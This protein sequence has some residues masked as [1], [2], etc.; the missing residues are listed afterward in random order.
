MVKIPKIKGLYPVDELNLFLV[1]NN[2][3]PST[4]ISLDPIYIDNPRVKNDFKNG[5]DIISGFDDFYLAFDDVQDFRKALVKEGL[6]FNKK[7]DS[8]LSRKNIENYFVKCQLENYFVASNKE[9]LNVLVESFKSGNDY[10]IG[11]ALGYPEEA[12]AHYSNQPK[13]STGSHFF[14]ELT[15]GVNSGVY[16]PSWIGYISHTPSRMDVL[17][18]DYSKECEFQGKLFE[19]FT[20]KYNPVLAM[21]VD[22]KFNRLL[23]AHK[24]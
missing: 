11:K 16:I 8:F 6:F 10:D 4:L 1:L 18:A 7:D 13:A 19:Q 23:E 12:C 2:L 22:G 20:R 14:N 15:I 24:K 9:N 5:R 21:K 17:K 3:K